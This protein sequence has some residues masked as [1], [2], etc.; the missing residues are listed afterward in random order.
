MSPVL[1]YTSKY[2]N[3]PIH[4]DDCSNYILKP[5]H[6]NER[7][8]QEVAFYEAIRDS[9]RNTSYAS[10]DEKNLASNAYN[11]NLRQ[12]AKV[13]RDLA[14][15]TPAY[16]G[17]AQFSDGDSGRAD[18][19]SHIILSDITASFHRPSVIDLKMGRRTY[20]P[21]AS[22][23]KRASQ[24][25]K[26]PQQSQFGFRI[27]GMNVYEPENDESRED[28]YMN[29]GKTFGQ[30]LGEQKDIEQAFALFFGLQQDDDDHRQASPTMTRRKV[31][32]VAG[33][34]QRLKELHRLLQRKI[35]DDAFAF[36]SSSI[37][38]VYEG[39]DRLLSPEAFSLKLIDFT[40]VRHQQGEDENYTYGLNAVIEC[41][42][43]LV[44][45]KL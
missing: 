23:E 31:Q 10:L 44:S 36:Y 3:Q 45:Q 22:P 17:V 33:I 12:R 30:S 35:I 8:L 5:F 15:F 32:L 26:Y 37:L 25:N 14:P 40:H 20:E 21:D 6:G 2:L 9:I 41:V 11:I 27:V 43:S 28:G 24:T 1:S 18:M 7:G 19:T 16:Y 4:G 29:F 39:D 13:L 34:L 38:I 42:E